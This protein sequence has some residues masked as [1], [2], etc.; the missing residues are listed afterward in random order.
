MADFDAAFAKLSKVCSK[1]TWNRGDI[2]K[3]MVLKQLRPAYAA[4]C[5][6]Y[7]NTTLEQRIDTYLY[8]E[9]RDNLLEELARFQ[10]DTSKQAVTQHAA[11][12]QPLA[13]SLVKQ[14]SAAD[15][16]VNGRCEPKLLDAAQNALEKAIETV[17]F[18]LKTYVDK[19]DLSASAF[20]KRAALLQK[21]GNRHDAIKALGI[22]VQMN[23][24]L[25]ANPKAMDMAASLT[26]KPGSA[27]MALI[28][29]SFERT[30]FINDQIREQN[31]KAQPRSQ[32][33]PES[34]QRF[35]LTTVAGMIFLAVLPPLTFPVVF[36]PDS[37]PD[38]TPPGLIVGTVTSVVYLMS[39]L[40][41]RP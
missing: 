14:A 7:E 40:K 17:G 19:L 31:K 28:G 29:D 32:R 33:K 5:A 21:E 38:N 23:P 9:T 39:Q 37:S 13:L 24:A 18:D 35:W 10:Q 4:L 8:F 30:M 26:G 22:A 3:K 15:L 12:K 25:T 1:I 6:A 34:P 20:A 2:P 36:G 41:R 27:A 11:N 16:I